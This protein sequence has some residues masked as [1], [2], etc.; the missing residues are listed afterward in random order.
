MRQ[1]SATAHWRDSARPARFFIFD[2]KAAFPMLL[3]FLHIKLWTFVV[4]V[5]CMLFFTILNRYGY[6][7]EV[8][9]R[10]FRSFLAGPRKFAVPWWKN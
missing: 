7:V 2:A 3:F 5:F 8:F 1:P 6:S 9:L 4:A 10:V